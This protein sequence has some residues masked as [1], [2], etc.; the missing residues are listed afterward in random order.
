VEHDI[1]CVECKRVWLPMDTD[2][3]QAYWLEE[4]PRPRLLFYCPACGEREFP[5]R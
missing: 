1:Q 2:R 3:W 5:K 4:G